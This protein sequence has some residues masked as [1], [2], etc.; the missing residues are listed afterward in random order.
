MRGPICS[1][2]RY[3]FPH[4]STIVVLSLNLD[5][6][7][8]GVSAET[9]PEK[10]KFIISE[11]PL[12]STAKANSRSPGTQKRLFRGS[13][14]GLKSLLMFLAKSLPCSALTTIVLFS[15]LLNFS[16][17]IDQPNSD[18]NSSSRS[19]GSISSPSRSKF[20]LIPTNKTSLCIPGNQSSKNSSISMA[21]G[22]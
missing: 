7:I 8:N 10:W 21:T 19:R 18:S 17:N 12:S 15:S 11:I 4:S 16:K 13:W 3:C 14:I 5:G 22:L 1:I 2:S 6:K 20:Q 9:R